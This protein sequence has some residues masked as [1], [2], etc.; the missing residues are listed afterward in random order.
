MSMIKL[1]ELRK[2]QNKLQKD[3]AK[4]LNISTQSYCNYDKEERQPNPEMLIRLAN[5]F[6]VS[7]DYLL[8]IEQ[9][10]ATPGNSDTAQIVEKMAQR[11]ITRERLAKLDKNQTED[12]L[13]LIEIFLNNIK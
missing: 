9:P 2:K 12:L 4:D 8:G 5:Y 1:L 10:T 6:N 3:I 11:G 13:N 7:V